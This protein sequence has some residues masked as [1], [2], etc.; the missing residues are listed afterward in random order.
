MAEILLDTISAGVMHI[1]KS[2]N[3]ARECPLAQD[4]QGVWYIRDSD[5]YH[6][7]LTTS[8]RRELLKT[9]SFL[10]GIGYSRDTYIVGPSTKQFNGRVSTDNQLFGLWEKVE[11]VPDYRA[12]SVYRFFYETVNKKEY[13]VFEQV[14]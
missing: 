12:E 3:R 1:D 4:Q 8:I 7:S 10:T 2:G 6:Y 9:V 5:N 11:E 14:K 13:F